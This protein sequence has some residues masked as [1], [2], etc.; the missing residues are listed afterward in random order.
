M[1]RRVGRKLVTFI[2][3]VRDA[4]RRGNIVMVHIGRCG[5]TV[6]GDLIGQHPQIRWE[7]EIY[8]Q[9]FMKRERAD[10]TVRPIL[11]VDPVDEVM[12]RSNRVLKR[13]Y[14]FETKFFHLR[15]FDTDVGSYLEALEQ[16]LGK[17]RII[18][19]RR[20]NTLRKVVSTLAAR[21]SGTWHSRKRQDG[22]APVVHVDPDSVFVNREAAPLLEL[23]REI[24]D[25][26]RTMD[27]LLEMRPHLRLT[28]EEDIQQ[29]PMSAYSK[30]CEFLGLPHA[31][32]D[33]HFHPTTP[34][35]LPDLVENFDEVQTL[36]T[37]TEFE[38]MLELPPQA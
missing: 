16:R 35:A 19:L 24:D 21:E 2:P 3:P 20:N 30:V 22:S 29:D 10:T 4:Y 34:G 32:V 37:G 33:I 18:H 17:L 14:G 38:W 1:L 6:L 5:S 25:D 23:L 26:Y 15:L 12:Q 11:D 27:A 31:P 7:G 13:F 9:V 36:L 8:Q 28:Y